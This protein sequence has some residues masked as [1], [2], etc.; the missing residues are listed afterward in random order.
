GFAKPM[1]AACEGAPGLVERWPLA[2]G[3]QAARGGAKEVARE[4]GREAL[5]LAELRPELAGAGVCAEVRQ[6]E[7]GVDGHAIFL[8]AVGPDGVE[9][10]EREP[11]V[12]HEDVAARAA[13]GRL[14]HHEPLARSGG[15]ARLEL[16]LVDVR[17]SRGQRRA[18]KPLANE[19]AAQRRR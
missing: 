13:G 17:R 16:G 18:E 19:L 14:V 6:R 7:L 8:L 5:V 9:V 11:Q 15:L 10:L 3:L 1:P 2:R 4:A 12:V